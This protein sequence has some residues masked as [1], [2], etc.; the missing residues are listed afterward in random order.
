MSRTRDKLKEAHFFLQKLKEHYAQHPDIDYYLSAFISSSRSVI[1]VMQSEY[2][3]I[4][5]WREW[6][7]SREPTLKEALFLKS[8][9]EVRI[10]SEKKEPL[11][12]SSQVAISI[13]KRDTTPDLK[14]ALGDIVDKRVK[15]T[16]ASRKGV[17]EKHRVRISKRSISF[18]AKI[19]EF[20]K[21]VEEFPDQDILP[22]CQKYYRILKL[23]VKECEQHFRQSS[24]LLPVVR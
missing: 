4:K 9:N 3:S 20:I 2:S 16:I 5:G 12:T 1:W 17:R 24:Q 6:Y 19:S 11:Q 21:V 8:I 7:D 15:V 23:L 14:E 10:R 18:V 13:S 22:I